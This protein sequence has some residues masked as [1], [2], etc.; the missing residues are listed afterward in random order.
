MAIRG[1]ISL[2][3]K[4]MANLRLNICSMAQDK[5]SK[6]RPNSMTAVNRSDLRC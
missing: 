6:V 3:V 4:V 1:V 2:V 5:D